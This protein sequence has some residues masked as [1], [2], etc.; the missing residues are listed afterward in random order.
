MYMKS[1]N[2]ITSPSFLHSPSPFPQ[3]PPTNIPC[4]YFTVLFFIF[5][6]KVNVQR[7]L[8]MCIDCTLVSSTP[9]VT[10]PFLFLLPTPIIQQ[11]SVHIIMSSTCT[12]V[13]HFD[14]VDY[15]YLY[16][17]LLCQVPLSSS[18]IINM[19]YIS[20]FIRYMEIP[21]RNSLYSYLKQTKMSFFFF[22]KI[23][24]EWNKSCL[25]G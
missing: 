4:T 20:K 14:T 8:S 2:H 22:F 11:L 19:F 16:F 6:S 25:G 5:N 7:G 9:S 12:E 18:T 1:I 13:M 10:L 21:Q 24:G 17:S 3:V 23:R 15:H